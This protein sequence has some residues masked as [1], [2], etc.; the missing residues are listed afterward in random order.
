MN[1][2]E[3]DSILRRH[4]RDFDSV[5]NADT[6]PEKPRLL[7]RNTDA[8]DKPG[9]HWICMHSENGRRENFDSF[10]RRPAANF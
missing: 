9:R 3:I 6:L 10:V 7:V 1:T 4:M 2:K 8:S 5:F